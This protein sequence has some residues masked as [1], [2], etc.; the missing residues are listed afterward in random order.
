MVIVQKRYQFIG[1]NG[2]EWT[3]W[4]NYSGDTTDTIQFKGRITLKNEYRTIETK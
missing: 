2:V 1:K 4:F 3:P